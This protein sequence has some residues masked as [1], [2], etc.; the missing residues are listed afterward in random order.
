MKKLGERVKSYREKKRLTR[1]ELSNNL[2]DESTIFRLEKSKQFPRLEI[3]NG[4]AEKLD[5]PLHNLLV[6]DDIEFIRLKKLCRELIYY[7]DY[8]ALEM[9]IEEIEKKLNN[10]LDFAYSE[11]E[12]KKFIQWHKSIILHKVYNHLDEAVQV[13]ESLVDIDCAF[14]E[15]DI[16]ILNSIGLIYLDL[17]Q[18]EDAGRFFKASYKNLKDL[19]V[20]EDITLPPRIG[21]NYCYLL[22]YQKHQDEAL[23]IAFHLLYY[24]KSNHLNYCMGEILFLIAKILKSKNHFEEA[25][26][27]LNSS[28]CA[29]LLE[30]ND[31]KVN[32]VQKN[33]KEI[34]SIIKKEAIQYAWPKEI[35]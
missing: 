24:L 1:R 29:F 9:V 11:V 7:E 13:L 26:T 8:F 27:Y 17:E 6:P 32:I 16:G 18:K 34:K 12:A 31:E 4:I 2:C 30:E 28:C 15:I 10:N 5:I 21:Y 33:V 19:S 35:L 22:Y 3:L 14:N 25:L 23:Q 20:I